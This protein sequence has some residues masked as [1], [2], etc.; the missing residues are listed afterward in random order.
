[1]YGL[2]RKMNIPKEID[3]IF[4]KVVEKAK[5]VSI[6]IYGSRARGDFNKESD[7][8]VGVLF[9]NERKWSRRELKELHNLDNL[10]LYPFVYE[11]FINYSVDTPF[12]T[13]I[14]LRDILMSAK[15]VRGKEVVEKM[16]LPEIK[17]SD[18]LERAT[19]DMGCAF[20]AIL[21][22][23]QNDWVTASSEF[24]K[25][26]LLGAR[27]LVALQTKKF[28]IQ[29]REITEE[30]LKLGLGTEY[31]D[32]IKHAL[33]VRSGAKPDMVQ[34]YTNITFLKQIVIQKI[35]DKLKTGDKVILSGKKVK[36]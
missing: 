20:C 16:E 26:V 11:D 6:F 33:D 28:P 7:Y 3:K 35:K 12:P 24:A 31:D 15:T 2:M 34:L 1:M 32:L 25:S 8:E 9:K 17:I 27:N 30:S 29:Y 13:V 22:S 18:L 10:N 4:D 36:S 14:Y 19:F 5:P 23:R 21:S